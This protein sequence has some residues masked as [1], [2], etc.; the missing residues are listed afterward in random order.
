[1]TSKGLAGLLGPLQIHS[2]PAP[3]AQ[4]RG[5]RVDAFDDA[6]ARYLPLNASTRQT[7]NNDGPKSSIS[8]CQDDEAVDTS[9]TAWR[10][11]EESCKPAAKTT[12]RSGGKGFGSVE[13]NEVKV[14]SGNPAFLEKVYDGIRL[15]AKITGTEAPLKQTL[16][17]DL[18]LESDLLTRLDAA[19]R[20]AAEGKTLRHVAL[21]D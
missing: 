21:D 12:R 17:A 19:K 5:Y 18:R 15:E 4:S 7:A 1:M 3:D 20:R 13:A 14:Q 11:W 10:G 6:R 16:D 2:C 9:K 8:T